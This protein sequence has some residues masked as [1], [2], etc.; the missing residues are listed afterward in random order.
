MNRNRAIIGLCLILCL[1][2]CK[3]NNDAH[4]SSGGSTT[5]STT[6]TLSF[7]TPVDSAMELIVS[8][9]AGKVLLDTV[10]A[11]K[12]TLSTALQTNDT[13]FDLTIITTVNGFGAQPD[14][15][16]FTYKAVNLAR[17]QTIFTGG[18]GAP[19]GSIPAST[20]A[21]ITYINAP[22]ISAPL[23]DFWFTILFSNSK[24]YDEGVTG[25]SYGP[26]AD[27]GPSI[28][29]FQYTQYGNNPEYILFP[30]SGQYKFHTYV[31]S[32]DTVD[33][34]Q[35]DT[36]ITVK[37]TRPAEYATIT[38]CNLVGYWDT[39]NYFNATLLFSQQQGQPI[40]YAIA[41]VE[42]P[43]EQCQAYE[44][45]AS[46]ANSN[47]DGVSWYSYG[48]TVPA[49]LSL[50]DESAYTLSS[51]TS[52]LFSLN[53]TS[54]QPTYYETQ[55]SE[56]GVYWTYYAAP[57]STTLHPISFLTA[58]NSKLLQ[59][60]NLGALSLNSFNFVTAQGLN[61]LNYFDYLT[62]PALLKIRRLPTVVSF[63]KNF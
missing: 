17:W 16:V 57:D 46:F 48:N 8:E 40:T 29:E 63:T 25:S 13:L 41:D 7:S 3:K 21:N 34:T 27:Y 32:N 56:G 61:Y 43:K 15:F 45:S 42:Y 59:G 33:L 55:Y 14:H 62:D 24:F 10:F 26:G 1:Y 6:G 37:F 36:A 23:T 19:T 12:G 51:S 50:P 22:Y 2:A 4:P 30:G 28:V 54:S 53:F 5:G 39:T 44:L 9:T 18:Y 49:T 31:T 58:L 11:N 47:N 60:Q 38:S 52:S 20:A 35:M